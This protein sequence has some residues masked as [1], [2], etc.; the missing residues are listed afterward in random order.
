MKKTISPIIAFSIIILI[1]GTAGA[2]IFLFSHEVEDEFLIEEEMAEKVEEGIIEEEI[3]EGDAFEDW[4]T[5]TNKEYNFEIKYPNDWTL[6]FREDVYPEVDVFFGFRRKEITPATND[7]MDILVMISK[8]R[9][10]IDYPIKDE[11]SGFIWRITD[12]EKI[13]V[14]GIDAYYLKSVDAPILDVDEI[15]FVYK[16]NLYIAK[17]IPWELKEGKGEAKNEEHRIMFNKIMSTFRFLD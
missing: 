6:I 2:A 17:V 1:A 4:K 13:S 14:S 7:Y 10:P 8:Q 16:K 12:G 11:S 15:Y 3:F 9:Q 5:Y